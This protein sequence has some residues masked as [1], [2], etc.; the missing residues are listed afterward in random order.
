MRLADQ[1]PFVDQTLKCPPDLKDVAREDLLTEFVRRDD[2][3]LVLMPVE[4]DGPSAGAN[5]GWL[6]WAGDAEPIVH[7]TEDGHL[8]VIASDRARPG[9]HFVSSAI[10]VE[11]RLQWAQHRR[12]PFLRG[13]TMLVTIFCVM[14][15]R[16]GRDRLAKFTRVFVLVETPITFIA[17][18]QFPARESRALR[19]WV[20]FQR[21]ISGRGLSTV[22]QILV[23]QIPT[24][25]AVDL[26]VV[27]GRRERSFETLRTPTLLFAHGRYLRVN[28]R[29][30]R[31]DCGG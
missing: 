22:I 19:V 23:I 9:G 26:A 2:L 8:D 24:I 17:I 25:D 30:A 1:V 14:V 12:R 11:A 28:I 15:F 20:R 13:S 3:P 6:I 31:H 10:R 7:N 21:L 29:D 16:C 4:I 18:M 5:T 27:V